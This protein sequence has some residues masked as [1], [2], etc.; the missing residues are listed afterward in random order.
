MSSILFNNGDDITYEVSDFTEEEE[1]KEETYP[2]LML[3]DKNMERIMAHFLC[4]FWGWYK[5]NK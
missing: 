1:I 5:W 3:E 4:S 2:L